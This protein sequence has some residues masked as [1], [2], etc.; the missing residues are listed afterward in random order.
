MD[1]KL[2]AFLTPDNFFQYIISSGSRSGKIHHSDVRVADHL[3]GQLDA[4]TQEVCGLS[5]SPCGRLLASGGNDNVLNV[6]EAATGE[7]YTGAQPKY[8]FR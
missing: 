6:W 2:A 1:M 5:W 8:T 7:C 3:V 4:H